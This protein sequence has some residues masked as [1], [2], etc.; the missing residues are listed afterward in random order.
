MSD[1]T[2]IVKVKKNQD[3][4]ITD[5]MLENGSIV[6]INHAILMAKGGSIEGAIVA[7]GKDGGEYI[8]TDPNVM[9]RHNLDSL[10]TFK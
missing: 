1:G 7:R 9:T 10:P 4:D 5:V 3:G 2:K 8:R 6:P